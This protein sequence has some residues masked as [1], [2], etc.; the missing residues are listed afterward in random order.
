MKALTPNIEEKINLQSAKPNKESRP[1][2]VR[3]TSKNQKSDQER[4]R[5]KQEE[6]IS[7]PEARPGQFPHTRSK[8]QTPR[9]PRAAKSP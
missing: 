7:R 9:P 3:D 5:E 2:P 4:V 8:N 6:K 1:T